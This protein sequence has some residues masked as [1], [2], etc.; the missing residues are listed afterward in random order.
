MADGTEQSQG[1]DLVGQTVGYARV[2]TISQNLDRQTAQLHEAGVHRIFTE[3]SSGGNRDRPV[4]EEVLR[5]LRD[6]DTLTVSSMDRL[7]RS[8]IDLR[9]L[10]DELT[11][12]GVAVSFLKESLTFRPRK[13]DPVAQLMLGVLG[14]IAEFD[15][16]LGR[17]RQADG[18]ARAK[19]KG[20][21]QRTPALNDEQV[22]EARRLVGEG[23]PKAEV[24]RRLGIGRTTLY[25][26]LPPLPAGE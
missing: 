20:K 18:I 2:S 23:V 25:R 1:L 8:S 9:N 7:A 5:Y 22:T 3:A 13:N 12:R 6:G 21:Y 24:A 11:G 17:E 4:L 19:A 26:Y 14:A 10:I 15:L 16:H